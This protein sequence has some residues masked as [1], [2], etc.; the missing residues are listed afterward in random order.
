MTILKY[1]NIDTKN[2]IGTTSSSPY[3]GSPTFDETPFHVQPGQRPRLGTYVIVSFDTPEYVLYGRVFEGVE[4]NLKADPSALQKTHAYAMP[5]RPRSGDQSPFVT[6]VMQI[7]ILG[8]LSITEQNKLV[9][10]E[11]VTLPLTNMKVYE[12][13]AEKIPELL[14]T[15]KSQEVGLYLG[16]I[17]IAGDSV[18]FYYPRIG[19]SRHIAVMGKTGTG[20]SYA[21][22]VMI[23][24]LVKHQIPVIAF[25]VLDDL[26]EATQQLGGI[27][28][29][30]GLNFKVPFSMIGVGEFINFIP[31]LTKDQTEIVALA[32]ARI[33]AE[34]MKQ[35]DETG[36]VTVSFAYLESRILEI[37]K[38]MGQEGVAQRAAQR[39]NAAYNGSSLLTEKLEDWMF[40][41]GRKSILNIFV[42]KLGQQQRNLVVAATARMLQ[43]LRRRDKV[44]PC[45]FTLD[46]AH[47]F[48][49]TGEQT[50]STSI[51]R[52][53]IRTA[54]HDAIGVI[55]ITQSPS[56]IDKQVLMICNTRLIFAL[57][58]EDIRAVEGTMGDVPDA[59]IKRLAKLP[60]GNAMITA[61]ADILRHSI[62]IKIRRRQTSEGAPT[63]DLALEAARWLRNLHQ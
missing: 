44:P 17:E 61:G 32:Y 53:M 25:D 2:V 12:L 46:E 24:E 19:L 4:E 57:D 39:V 34:A 6:R 35:L 55:L 63:P 40:Q 20:K 42:G 37:G 23:E 3:T 5:E 62:R 43:V 29:E 59:I 27:Q 49:P 36:Q 52:E 21:T 45:V 10:A 54:R 51:I 50:P 33:Q 1:L 15:A 22:G 30:A 56:S 38:N 31:N 58:R 18:P 9:I 28:Y 60:K 13:P 8:E 47:Y 41:L 14:G 48:L 26:R 11:P 16:D 7:E